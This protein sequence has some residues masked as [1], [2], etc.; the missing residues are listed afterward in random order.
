ML[1]RSRIEF[2]I[3][4][5][6]LEDLEKF[7]QDVI[8]KKSRLAQAGKIQVVVSMGSCGIAAGAYNTLQAVQEQIESRHL[9]NVII[10]KTGC[11]GHCSE[12]PILIV[13][14]SDDQKTTYGHASS[15]L[16][17]Q[18]FREHILGGNIIRKHQL[19]P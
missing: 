11:I 17:E 19:S 7:K 4:I 16:V 10:S 15:E 13:I 8:A 1:N 14:T 18:I 5:Q 6:S 2:M 12:E 9:E 3:A